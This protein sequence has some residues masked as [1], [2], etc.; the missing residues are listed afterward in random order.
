MTRMAFIAAVLLCTLCTAAWADAP[1]T[2]SYQGVLTDA[3]GRAVSDGEYGMTFRIYDVASGGTALWTETQT[4]TVAKGIFDVVLGAV[5]P[6]ALPF[7]EQYWLGIS[8]EGEGE[9]SPRIPL[10]SSAY[11]L[12]T[13]GARGANIIPAT[14]SVGIGTLTPEEM[15]DVAGG[16]RIGNTT[17]TSAGA[18]R[19][20]GTDFEGYNGSAW[21]SF[22]EVGSG[23]VP[24]GTAGQTLRHTGSGWEATGSLFNSGTQIGIGTTAPTSALDILG[25]ALRVR[26]TDTQYSELRN[27]NA[28][29]G[30][31][32]A[33]S[34]ES[35]KK[36]LLIGAYHDGSGSP[37]GETRIR[38]SVGS[39]AAP[40]H[41][42][43]IK[44]TGAV[45]IGTIAPY[46]LFE[47]A[48]DRAFARLVSSSSEGSVL[49]LKSTD[50]SDMRVH[51]Q[52][53]FLDAA[54]GR[55]AS[56]ASRY[57]NVPSAASGLYLSTDGANRMVVADNGNVG[58]GTVNPASNLEVNGAT[59][60]MQRDGAPGQYL[61][62]RDNDGIG[63]YLTG[64]S[65]GDNRKPLF[66]SCLH[67]ASGT[68]GG[69]TWIRFTVG[70]IGFPDHAMVIRGTGNVGIGTTNPSR[71]LT[72]R[73]NL[74]IESESTGD[75]VVEFG[76][77]LDYAEGFDVSD[78]APPEPGTVLVIDPKTPG[79]L[80]VSA[81][82]YDSRVA[83]IVA[84]A[85]GLG[86]GVRLGVEQFDCD[87]ALAGRVYCNVDA[88]G[89]AI[90]PG[91]LLTTSAIPGYAMKAV[92]RTAAQGAILGKAMERLERGTKGRILVL[93]SLQ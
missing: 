61:E 35:N 28:D 6:L 29:G 14:G 32:T 42:M 56:I 64:Y 63:A 43:Y 3:D 87:V 11:S 47:V 72:V 81:A 79:K 46:R 75:P 34:P 16:I 50:E 48:A 4:G 69:E 25:G 77:G 12:N 1:R 58:I 55:R 62:I 66:I 51:G 38:F 22:T 9:L 18:M 24:S 13:L 52:I 59:I 78:A 37:S 7:D 89:S 21:Q 60:R 33:F 76:E 57:L 49:E 27:N 67:D 15:L 44:E 93:V 20:T 90:E 88:T 26:R 41:A 68:P 92:D 17:G 83:G 85:N 36:P 86:S 5:V 54:D 74:L 10:A 39:A 91:D 30:Y 2:L 23:T 73:G 84:G 70:S 45:G 53:D 19:W 80:A 40:V 82:A 31:L 8:V 65:K 71:K